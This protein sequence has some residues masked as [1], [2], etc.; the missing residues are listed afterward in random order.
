MK[1]ILLIP[2]VALLVWSCQKDLKPTN[3][4]YIETVRKGLQDSLR[5]AD[6]QALDFSKA[7]HSSVDSVGL[8]FLRIPFKGMK[9][10]EDFVMV[11]TTESGVIQKGKIVH[12]QGKIEDHVA[13]SLKTKTWNGSI[14]LTS[15]DRKSLFQSPIENGYVTALHQNNRYRTASHEPEGKVMPEVIIVYTIPSSGGGFSWSTWFMLQLPNWGGGGGGGGGGYYSDFSG[16]GSSRGGGGYSSGGEGGNGSSNGEGYNDPVIHVDMEMQ[17]ED[18]PIDIEKFINCFNAIPDAGAN[19]SIEIL[20]D[21]PVD[22]DPNKIFNFTSRS[23]GHT[24][25]NIRKSNGSQSVSQNIGFYPKLGWK[26]LLSYAPI[27]GKFVDNAQHEYNCGFKIS[28]T[29]QQLRSALAMMQQFKSVKYD[30]DNFNCTDWALDVFNTAGGNLQIPYYDIPGN[31]S[32]LGTR[33]PN[34]VYNKLQQ[35]KTTQHPLA[36]GITINIV[37][38]FAG[39]ST[40]PCN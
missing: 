17:D 24:F 10:N 8:Y 3:N 26:T 22:S 7:A 37:K 6:F 25:L 36:G 15:L 38:G 9:Q 27:D 23:P 33:T 32:N 19:C 20:A 16:G 29:P 13:G 18:P 2:F 30:I 31:P 28:I 5:T 4:D 21:I 14:S 1:H 35:M 39:N 34:G 40:G 11:Q 12:L